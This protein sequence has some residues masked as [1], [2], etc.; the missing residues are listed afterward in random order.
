MSE[1]A[2]ERK[3]ILKELRS[4]LDEMESSKVTLIGDIMLVR[5]NHGYSN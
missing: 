4:L 1:G 2:N 3:K 5:Y